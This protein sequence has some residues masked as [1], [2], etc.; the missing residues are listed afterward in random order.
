M[1]DVACDALDAGNQLLGDDFVCSVV[2]WHNP[3]LRVL[4]RITVNDEVLLVF[5]H[6]NVQVVRWVI[7]YEQTCL[8]ACFKV[9]SFDCV[10]S[11]VSITLCKEDNLAAA[12]FNRAHIFNFCRKDF[13]LTQIFESS[14][15]TLCITDIDC[16]R[17]KV[18]AV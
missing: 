8:L 14:G 6:P 4:L 11:I 7:I 2:P 18:L 17:D 12:K 10:R 1:V 16:E 15:Q 3:N 13:V 5:R 9:E